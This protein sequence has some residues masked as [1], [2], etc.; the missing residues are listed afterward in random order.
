MDRRHTTVIAV[1]VHLPPWSPLR[2]SMR[3]QESASGVVQGY[4]DCSRFGRERQVLLAQ[5]LGFRP[6]ILPNLSMRP[7]VRH[8]RN[9]GCATLLCWPKGA[10]VGE[11]AVKDLG[12]RAGELASQYSVQSESTLDVCC[13]IQI[14]SV[15]FSKKERPLRV[16][17]VVSIHHPLVVSGDNERLKG[18]RAH[19]MSPSWRG[20]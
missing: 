10:S 13:T 16:L 8:C 4:L 7:P 20:C 6:R 12:W 3:L 18:P 15:L 2:L 19:T 11:S 14:L 1:K 5:V 9:P 17:A